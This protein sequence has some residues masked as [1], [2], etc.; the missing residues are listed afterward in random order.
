MTRRDLAIA[1]DEWPVLRWRLVPDKDFPGHNLLG[2]ARGVRVE[3]WRVSA[4]VE[5]VASP[6]VRRFDYP[7]G[8][9]LRAAL[10]DAR[11]I[12]AA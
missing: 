9:T 12:V 6:C 11:R 2:T 5:G 8:P 1:R 7:S 10:R 4:Y 3:L